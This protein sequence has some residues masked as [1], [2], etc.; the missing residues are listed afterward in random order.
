MTGVQTCALPIY[1]I[2]ILKLSDEKYKHG[3]SQG[4]E[5]VYSQI[6]AHV[7]FQFAH[8]LHLPGLNVSENILSCTIANFPEIRPSWLVLHQEEHFRVLNV[9]NN[10]LPGL[11]ILRT[12]PFP[13]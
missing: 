7:K 3:R 1:R 6:P 9:D 8:P 10:S 12:R 2:D 4:F 5:I 11:Q 13:V